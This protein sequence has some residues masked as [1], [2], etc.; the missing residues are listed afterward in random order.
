[1]TVPDQIIRDA[2]RD[3]IREE[4]R[5]ERLISIP[6]AAQIL[7]VSPDTARKLLGAGYDMGGKGYKVSLAEIDRI[8]AERR[9]KL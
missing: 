4:V 9:V 5:N 8:K 7:D 2:V 6:Q 1:M 3:A